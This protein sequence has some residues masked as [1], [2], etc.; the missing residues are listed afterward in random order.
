MRH[1]LK[2]NK[3]IKDWTRM[4]TEFEKYACEQWSVSKY[5]MW[6]KINNYSTDLA[7]EMRIAWFAWVKAWEMSN[8]DTN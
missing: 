6:D 5:F 4:K 1:D 3:E 8:N 2:Q 7:T